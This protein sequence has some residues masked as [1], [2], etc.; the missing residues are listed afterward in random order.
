[1]TAGSRI[2]RATRHATSP[3]EPRSSGTDVER[4]ATASGG[5]GSIPLRAPVLRTKITIVSMNLSTNCTNRCLRLAQALQSRYDVE[6][7][8]TTFGVGANWGRGLWPP[9]EGMRDVA[10]RSVPGDY[11][12]RY[13]ASAWKLLKAM[14]GDVIIACKPRAPS[15]GIAIVKKLLSGKPV[16][17]DIDD[18]EIAQTLPGRRASWT[19]QLASVG[20][21][22]WTR[23]I[24]PLHRVVDAKF[25]VSRNFLS[26]YGGVIVPHPMSPVEL[27]P[28]RFDRE[29]TRAGFG[30][31][32]ADVV[33]GFVGTPGRQK[34][35]DLLVSLFD[36]IDDPR[37]KL[38][39][40]GADTE[41]DDI[42]AMRR[43]AGHRLLVLPQQPLSKLPEIL[44]AMDI[45]ALPQ[46]ATEETWGQMPAK[47]TD[48]MAMGKPIV[49][50][51]RADIASYLAEG[52]GL[53]FA[54]ENVEDF[55]S[56]IRWLLEHPAARAAMGA[57][58]RD[59]FLQHLTFD[60][61]A[62]KMVPVIDRLTVGR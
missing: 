4:P 46:R 34:G 27:D 55:A 50:A 47:L 3:I 10:I 35:T 51:D 53:T 9:L 23:L 45:I 59:Y 39:I 32:E 26:R 61:V 37:L 13:L 40:V 49:A 21:Y 11:L 15:L 1:M 48:A 57:A 54:A 20:G 42:V 12:P 22:L 14:D 24:H 29:A 41:D 8:G 44:T 33:V 19:K 5:E 6:I 30:L 25:V 2:G 38:M 28:M 7:V 16:I 36:R 60:A 56:R 18:D 17:L 58:A 43:K 31:T 62:A 52:R